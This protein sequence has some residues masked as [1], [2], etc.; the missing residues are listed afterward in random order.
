MPVKSKVKRVGKLRVY[1]NKKGRYIKINGR[2]YYIGKKVKKPQLEKFVKEAIGLQKKGKETK[3]ATNTKPSLTE[4][5]INDIR[6]LQILKE[7]EKD[8]KTEEIPKT[9]NLKEILMEKYPDKYFELLQNSMVQLKSKLLQLKGKIKPPIGGFSTLNNKDKIINFML[10]NELK[11]QL[12][13]NVIRKMD[14]KTVLSPGKKKP[15]RQL[16]IIIDNDDDDEDDDE[17]DDDDEDDDDDD[18]DDDDEERKEDDEGRL[19]TD[20]VIRKMDTK[21][22]LSPGKKKP[23][24]EIEIIFD[25][26]DDEDDDVQKGNGNM[27]MGKNGLTN[28]QIDDFMKKYNGY[29][30]CISSDEISTLDIKPKSKGGFIINTDPS[31]KPGCHWQAVYF[32]SCEKYEMC[33]FDSFGDDID[34]KLYNELEKLV[35][36]L[37]PDYPLKF[38]ENKIDYQS[39][40]S[41]NCG[42]FSIKFLTLML[43]GHPFVESSGFSDFVRGEKMIEKFKIQNGGFKYMRGKGLFYTDYPESVKKYLIDEP[44]TSLQIGRKPINGMLDKL[45]NVLSLGGWGKAKKELGYSDMFHLYMIINGKYVLERNHVVEM[46]K[47]VP[48]SNEEKINV[49]VNKPLTV[50]ELLENTKERIGPELQRYDASS[51]NCQ[52][53][54]SQILNA[55]G[56]NSSE[57][58]KFVNQDVE[59]VVKKQPWYLKYLMK[60]VTDVGHIINKIIKR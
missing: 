28:I 31:N 30:G 42:W 9:K 14:P 27:K 3:D 40:Y 4:D 15:K 37:E 56:L 10:E 44:I 43:T 19:Y 51:N 41:A 1:K 46:Y 32:D 60:G 38:K 8:V 7:N 58:K 59:S 17:N 16:E 45:I 39:D 47:Y 50:K 57:A 49:V 35:E 21:T 5:E 26:D 36:R 33:F 34:A 54:Q 29:L 11:L 25:D 24:E 13:D 12:K 48:A 53:F 22:V 18:D 6:N 2:V 20:K 55:N 52:V 23:K